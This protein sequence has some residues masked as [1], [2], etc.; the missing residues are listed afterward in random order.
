MAMDEADK[1]ALADAT[2]RMFS[3]AKGGKWE[4]AG[5]AYYDMH[6]IVDDCLDAEE[7]E[8]MEKEEKGEPEKGGKRPLAAILIGGSKK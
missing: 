5:V 8:G 3:A 4:E 2:E 1:A 7:G 6:V